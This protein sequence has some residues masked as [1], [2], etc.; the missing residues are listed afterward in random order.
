M[1]IN[2]VTDNKYKKEATINMKQNVKEFWK[3][4]CEI[5]KIEIYISRE[6]K[7]VWNIII[8][9]ILVIYST[10]QVIELGKDMLEY[11]FVLSQK[12]NLNNNVIAEKVFSNYN[13]TIGI[14]IVVGIFLVPIIRMLGRIKKFGKD[15]IETFDEDDQTN[16]KIVQS[17]K[18]DLKPSIGTI[19]GSDDENNNDERNEIELLKDY[20]EKDLL[21]RYELKSIEVIVYMKNLTKYILRKLYYEKLEISQE[22]VKKIISEMKGYRNMSDISKTRKAKNIIVFLEN[23]DIIESDEGEEMYIITPFGEVVIKNLGI[24]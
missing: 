19:I 20:S 21:N 24:M 3:K 2:R 1:V 7:K 4:L 12:Y 5:A 9:C 17:D 11:P 22:Q 6:D 13:F 16:E 15:G 23:N 14:I 18:K 10:F 8:N